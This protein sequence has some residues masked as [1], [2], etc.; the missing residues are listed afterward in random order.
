MAKEPTIV[1]PY[2]WTIEN[3]AVS[4]QELFQTIERAVANCQLPDIKVERM[5]I[6]ESGGMFSKKTFREH[7]RIKCDFTTFQAY[8]AQY[9]EKYTIIGMR[10]YVNNELNQHMGVKSMNQLALPR[11]IQNL[12]V[13]VL[14]KAIVTSVDQ[15]ITDKGERP[16]WTTE[17]ASEMVS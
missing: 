9:A 1:T 15:L 17:D 16:V 4:A 7:L 14:E 3:I 5:E 12:R 13:K 8:T 2:V 10:K 6:K 11:D